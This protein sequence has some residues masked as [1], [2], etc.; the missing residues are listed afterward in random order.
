[1]IIFKHGSSMQ[2]DPYV[3]FLNGYYYYVCA[4]NG[5]EIYIAKLKDIF[6]LEEAKFNLV[7][8]AKE[9]TMYSKELWA[10]EL[11]VIDNKCYIYVACDDGINDNH[12]MYVLKND[13]DDPLKPYD[14][15]GK[16]SDETDKWAID[17]SVFSYENQLYFIWS[18]WEG[19]ENVMQEI[20]IAKMSDPFTISSKRVSISKPE[21]E[22]ELHGGT[23]LVNEGPIALIHG[24]DLFIS[25]SASGCWTNHYCVCLLKLVGKDLLDKNSWQKLDKPLVEATG[26]LKGPGHN[27]FTKIDGKDYIIFHAYNKDCSFGGHSVDVHIKEITWENDFPAVKL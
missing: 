16:I 21:L 1:M 18:G 11:H 10:P 5:N 9:N 27:S 23:P 13:S 20:Y 26:C 2:R 3:L 19:N 12:R 4:K 15:V 14:F 8:K 24:K 6:K 22:F 7:Y 25:Y 17:G